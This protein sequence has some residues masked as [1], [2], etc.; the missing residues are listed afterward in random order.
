LGADST[1]QSVVTAL[2]VLQAFTPTEPVLG[3]SEVSRRLGI[4]KSTVHRALQT[5]AGEGFVTQTDG[6][7]YRLGLKLYA[8]GMQVVHTSELREIAH[9]HIEALHTR[10]GETAH[11]SVL[12]GVDVVFI[13]RLESPETLRVFS[14]FGARGPAHATSTGRAILAHADDGTVDAVLAAGLDPLTP[15]TRCSADALRQTLAQVRRNGYAL[16]LEEVEVGIN[17]VAAPVFDQRNQAVAGPAVAGPT[18]RI[19]ADQVHDLGLLVR[20]AAEDI[21]RD[22]ARVRPAA[23][24]R[25]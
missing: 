24:A 5:L 1:I 3:V 6:G 12:D 17:S 14:R 21:S 10:T 18:S 16:C 23:T 13:D 11:L 15:M 2:R 8:L 20:R 7:R 4:G 19:R 22:L 25:A 9:P